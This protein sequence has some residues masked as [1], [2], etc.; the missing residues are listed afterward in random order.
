VIARR[1]GKIIL[2]HPFELMQPIRL[3]FT[4]LKRKNMNIRKS[5]QKACANAVV[6]VPLVILNTGPVHAAPPVPARSAAPGTAASKPATP[7]PFIFNRTPYPGGELFKAPAVPIQWTVTFQKPSAP[8]STRLK[9]TDQSL[10]KMQVYMDGIKTQ[11]TW[12]FA[13]GLKQ[14][15]WTFKNI[16]LI[17]MPDSPLV[18]FSDPLQT[19]SDSSL[20]WSSAHV[21]N[22]SAMEEIKW[23][24]PENFVSRYQGQESSYL[25]FAEEDLEDP[26]AGAPAPTPAANT[27]PL[28]GAAPSTS[29]QSARTTQPAAQQFPPGLIPGIPLKPTIRAALLDETTRLPKRVQFGVETL[30]YTYETKP[31][32][33]PIPK[34]IATLLPSELTSPAKPKAP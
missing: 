1:L 16:R 10:V 3:R 27:K 9:T 18:S 4:T 25:I 28:Q 21:S 32:N 23:I 6:M 31:E 15:F 26:T 17:S 12:E 22:W 7:T 13:H 19:D 33:L 2:L 14:E 34:K 30:I 5:L 29:A 24:K 20:L 8:S 11:E